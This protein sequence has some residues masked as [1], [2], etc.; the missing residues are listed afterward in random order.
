VLDYVIIY[1]IMRYVIAL[2]IAYVTAFRLGLERRFF[3]TQCYSQA[4]RRTV[5]VCCKLT[6]IIGRSH[7][8]TALLSDYIT[9][10][11]NTENTKNRNVQLSLQGRSK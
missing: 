8:V 7:G 6:I 11:I 5:R 4:A 10:T 3:R 2:R 1:V 9:E